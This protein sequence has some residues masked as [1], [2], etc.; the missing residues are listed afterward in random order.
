[1][2]E[3]LPGQGHR[4]EWKP[5]NPG[6]GGWEPELATTHV[7]ALTPPL[8]FCSLTEPSQLIYTHTVFGVVSRMSQEDFI[9]SS[10]LQAHLQD[11]LASFDI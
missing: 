5:T 9:T 11:V 8:H 10:T 3:L 6:T 4:D 2:V 7:T 1:M